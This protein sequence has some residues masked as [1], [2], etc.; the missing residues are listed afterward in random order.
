M[1]K[2]SV[3]I[4]ILATLFSNVATAQTELKNEFKVGYGVVSLP[5]IGASLGNVIGV[6]LGA[7][8]GLAVGDVVSV[9]V[10]GTPRNVTVT[11]IESNNR[12]YGT[13]QAGY[14]RY[15]NKRLSLGLQANYTS[16]DFK[17]TVYYSNGTQNTTTTDVDFAQLFGRLDVHYV[18][19]PKFQM[20][21]GIAAG[22]IYVLQDNT[23][24]FA[25]HVNLLGFR[26]GKNNAIYG[27]F[28][29][30]YSS[31]FTVGFSKRF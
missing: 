4:V 10:N 20:Y 26:I 1:K 8:L 7:N 11:Q 31:T 21:S 23:S 6:S 9:L 30:G 13:F 5:E 27:E 25:A 18:Q 28:G 12:F 16:I 3:I 19:K 29:I 22:A 15:L 2:L 17:T 14:N 24:G